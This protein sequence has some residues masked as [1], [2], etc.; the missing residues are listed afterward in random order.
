MHVNYPTIDEIKAKWEAVS[1]ELLKSLDTISARRLASKPPFQTS[2]P[3]N[4]LLG[5]IAFMVIH[6]AHHIG[7]ISAIRKVSEENA[8][9]NLTDYDAVICN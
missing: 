6:E 3:D 7:Q 5:L 2:I 4:T 8:N 1:P 9:N